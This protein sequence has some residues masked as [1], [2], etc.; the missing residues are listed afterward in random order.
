MQKIYYENGCLF[1]KTGVMYYKYVG[2]PYNIYTALLLSNNKT[3]FIKTNLE[4]IDFSTS[5]IDNT[6]FDITSLKG[7]IIDKYQCHNLVGLLGVKVKE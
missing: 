2:V 5:N 7:I 4:Q 6:I 1:V 3:E